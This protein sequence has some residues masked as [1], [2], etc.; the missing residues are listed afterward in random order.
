MS[1]KVQSRTFLL[2][3]NYCD[4]I[5]NGVF[6]K[7]TCNRQSDHL[8]WSP[9]L[10]VTSYA[11]TSAGPRGRCWNP[12]LKCEGFNTSRGA[13][14]MLVNQKNMFDRYYCMKTFCRSKTLE[15]ML[16][17][18]LFS[19]TYNGAEGHVTCDIL[20]TPLPGQRLTRTLLCT[21][22]MMTSVF[23]TAPECLYVK[24]QSLALTA[25]ELPC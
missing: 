12:S 23:V 24:P 9:I 15:K 22:L 18:V 11:L 13:Q 5:S 3:F 4:T 20:K 6:M 25:R 19:C 10:C 17:K 2:M 8:T 14:Q 21:L 7:Q 16:R 1:W